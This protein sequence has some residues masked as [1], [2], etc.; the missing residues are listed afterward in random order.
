MSFLKNKSFCTMPWV[1]M[2]AH[3]D[4]SPRLCC[5]SNRFIKNNKGQNFNLGNDTISEIFNSDDINQV[6]NDMIEGKEISGC[7]SCYESEKYSGTSHRIRYNKQW[8]YH[9]IFKNKINQTLNGKP[10]DNT[11]EFFDIRYG[12]MCNLSCR[13]C[14]SEASSQYNKEI[15]EIT[16]TKNVNFFNPIDTDFNSWYETDT[17]NENIHAQIP[18]L[19]KYYVAGGEPTI[20]DKNYDVMKYMVDSGHSK[21]IELQI[22]TNLTNTK[23]DFYSLL[24]H[25]KSIIFLASIDGVG[26]IQEYMRY[27]SKWNQIESNLKKVLSMNLPNILITLNPVLQKVNLEYIVDLLE[28]AE[29]INRQSNKSIMTVVPIIL[30]QPNYFDFSYLPLDYKLYCLDKID[31]W[32][33][34]KCKFQ[35]HMFF[36]RLEHIRKKCTEET[37]YDENLKEFFKYI[38]IFDQHRNHNLGDINPTLNTFRYK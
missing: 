10:V 12:N 7:E 24:H 16:N 1:H 9:P 2:A 11:I 20:I 38:D 31:T 21:H 22:S 13:Y 14:Y 3:T 32:V 8:S 4:G 26:P 29:D 6:R 25:F 33:K 36:S 34:T 17:F 37:V 28:Y 5:M 35:N 18:N 23:K 15:T 19:E 30:S 27:P